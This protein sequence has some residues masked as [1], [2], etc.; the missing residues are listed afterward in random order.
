[1]KNN[2]IKLDFDHL[3]YNIDRFKYLNECSPKYLVVNKHTL[4]LMAGPENL[5]EGSS[6]YKGIRIIVD[7]DLELGMIRIV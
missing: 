6:K 3:D 7:D 2:Y 4:H 5:R 1:M